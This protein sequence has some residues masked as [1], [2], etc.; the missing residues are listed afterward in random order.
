MRGPT[1]TATWTTANLVGMRVRGHSLSAGKAA[2]IPRC[3]NRKATYYCHNLVPTSV[4]T[5]LRT[6]ELGNQFSPICMCNR[7]PYNCFNLRLHS[8][9]THFPHTPGEKQTRDAGSM[10]SYGWK[11][12][13]IILPLEIGERDSILST[14]M[15]PM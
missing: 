15:V 14:V 12:D 4:L 11:N 9:Q 3:A 5:S 8:E 6:L 13:G 7:Q 2:F 10:Q 1:L